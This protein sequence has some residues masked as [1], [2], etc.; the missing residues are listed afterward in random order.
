MEPCNST[1]L[2]LCDFRFFI[3]HKLGLKLWKCQIEWVD[4]FQAVIDGDH[5]G[6]Q[7][8]A[9]ADH[10]KTSR[11]VIPAILWLLAR[12]KSNRI[13]II[14]NC[15]E[16]AEQI[17]RAVK[18]RIERQGILESE[19]GLRR[20]IKWA[21]NEIHIDRPNWE[22]KDASLL[23]RGVGAD[24]QS[25]RFDYIIGDD[26]AT[27]KNSRT[28]S[29]RA[30][31]KTYFF[32]DLESR[33]DEKP[34]ANKGKYLL[35]G[36]RVDANDIYADNMGREEEGWLY[37]CDKAILDETA[38]KV[39]APEHH[40]YEKLCRKRAKDTAGFDL[41]FQ[42][43]TAAIGK[44]LTRTMME[45]V[46]RPDLHFI[47]SMTPDKRAEFKVTWLTLDP[48]FSTSR[49]S[50]YSVLMLWGMRADG[51]KVLLWG[52]RDKLVPD[53]LE[54]I[55]DMKFRLYMPDYFCIEGNAAQVMLLAYMKRMHPD[56]QSKFKT[57][58]TTNQNG[59]L[60]DDLVRM[61]EQYGGDKPKIE[62]PYHG[63]TEQSFAQAMCEEFVSY[64]NGRTRDILMAQYIGE[65]GLGLI[66]QEERKGYILPRGIIG[67]VAH[68]GRRRFSY[69]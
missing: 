58:Y 59:T 69:G 67:A 26:M 22:E 12:D 23:C 28:E 13:A 47:N 24:V 31:I 46:R 48:A 39:L 55:M 1:E 27:R 35:T 25:Q 64:P 32:T 41:V 38:Q 10:G 57:V 11:L 29:Q 61:F 62:L 53:A 66:K 19:F 60:D 63:P 36:H 8:L 7:L 43:E 34:L 49:W 5:R 65:K 30:A 44:F 68:R 2:A 37:R 56:H 15:D 20:G 4:L 42:Q 40:T 50:F 52:M 54:R 33:M 18:T 16:Y 17:G 45:K 3:E 14:G 21:D 6:L 51:A 9:P